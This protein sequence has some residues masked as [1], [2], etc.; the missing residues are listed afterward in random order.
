MGPNVSFIDLNDETHK[1]MFVLQ[2]HRAIM[3][4]LYILNNLVTVRLTSTVAVA[5][6]AIIFTP[7]GNK[8]RTSPIRSNVCRNDSPLINS[9]QSMIEMY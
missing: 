2:G 1:V 9:T 5:V 6:R 8:L 7:S 3:V 4:G